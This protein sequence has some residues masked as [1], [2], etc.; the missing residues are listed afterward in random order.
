MLAR[1]AGEMAK[2]KKE[3]GLRESL[4]APF[5]AEGETFWRQWLR[6]LR[7]T[8]AFQNLIRQG[9]ENESRALYTAFVDGLEPRNHRGLAVCARSIAQR[10][11]GAGIPPERLIDS[12]LALRDVH[13]HSLVKKYGADAEGL[14]K[15]LDVYSSAENRLL[16]LVI[17]DVFE[18]KEAAA[19]RLRG[20][21]RPRAPPA[22]QAEM[23]C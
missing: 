9:L 16:V 5:R 22:A 7:T 4:V 18:A 1:T 8:G 12:L 2:T 3:T 17:R 13:R 10:A 6:Q 23:G 19:T 14:A 11:L 21:G 20:L 15:A